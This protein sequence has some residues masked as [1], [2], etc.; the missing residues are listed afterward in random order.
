VSEILCSEVFQNGD[1]YEEIEDMDACYI[2]IRWRAKQMSKEAKRQVF[3]IALF[4]VCV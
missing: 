3:Q 1:M 4:R 2:R